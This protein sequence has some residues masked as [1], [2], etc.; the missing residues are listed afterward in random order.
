MS[1]TP[2]HAALLAAGLLIIGACSEVP[3]RPSH[4]DG[5]RMMGLP[6]SHRVACRR[7]VE[8]R[9]ACP[10][11]IPVV[12]SNE[13]RAG[14]F[15][16]G[17]EHFLFFSEWS[18]PYPGVTS[19]NSPPRFVHV[20]VHAGNLERAFAFEWPLEGGTLPDRI[21]QRRRESV[22]LDDAIWFGNEGSLILAPSFPHG[23]IDGDHV[24]FRW[25]EGG[26]AYAISL[27]A[28]LPLPD[29]VASLKAVFAT[30]PAARSTD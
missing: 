19:K 25:E 24:M 26:R 8:L 3:P 23:G 9:R 11:E 7:F 2:L 17:K 6:Q 10:V 29:A 18:G 4:N 30:T 15:R 21:P 1:M 27:H 13:E 12:K 16:S 22:L 14:S 28:W 20:N 5:I